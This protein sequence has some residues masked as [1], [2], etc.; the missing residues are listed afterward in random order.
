MLNMKQS[1]HFY[2][3]A[4]AYEASLILEAQGVRRDWVGDYDT[5]AGLMA[6][7]LG[8]RENGSRA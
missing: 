3:V 5:V 4:L 1:S 2:T 7:A 8:D 6:P